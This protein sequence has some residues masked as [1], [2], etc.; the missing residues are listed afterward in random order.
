[1]KIEELTCNLVVYTIQCSD[2]IQCAVIQA[3]PEDNT[4]LLERNSPVLRYARVPCSEVYTWE[5]ANDVLERNGKN[6]QTVQNDHCA[7]RKRST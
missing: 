6:G 1:M 3:Y 7:R 4:V 2:I 5:Q